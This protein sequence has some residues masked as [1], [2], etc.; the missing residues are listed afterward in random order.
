[1][2]D[3]PQLLDHIEA[4]ESQLATTRLADSWLLGFDTETTGATPGNDAIVSATLVLR[5]P[6]S[7]HAEDLVGEWLINPHRH[8]SA[9]ASRVNGFTD[10][11]VEEHG[12]E[13]TSALEEISAV[14]I[15]AQKRNIPLLAYNAPFD[16]KM[17]Q[18]D[19]RRWQCSPEITDAFD[20][21]TLLI[22]DPLVIDRA[23][24]RRS[25]KRTLSFTTEY[26]GV[27]PYGDFHD[28]TADTI[29]AVDLVKPISTLYPQVG[30]LELSELMDWQRQAHR[31]W[32]ES[33]NRWLES[34]G[35]RPIHENWFE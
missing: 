4:A 10:S 2:T 6:Q 24:S 9:G 14:I 11:F 7:G 13:P 29:A 3:T 33:F 18:G 26:Y 19:L 8:I 34:K 32:K 1:M 28:A 21:S 23:V 30:N 16:V 22:V 27:E 12:S 15:A 31:V 25:G 17:L 35:R 5:N 20:D